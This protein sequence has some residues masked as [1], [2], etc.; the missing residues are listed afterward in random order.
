MERSAPKEMM[1]KQVHTVATAHVGVFSNDLTDSP[2]PPNPAATSTAISLSLSLST[3]L[4]LL[5]FLFKNSS[6]RI[7]SQLQSSSSSYY[8]HNSI[9]FIT[10]RCRFQH[11]SLL[12][13]HDLSLSLIPS[14]LQNSLLFLPKIHQPADLYNL[15][16]L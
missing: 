12:F 14:H 11:P 16:G 4:V 10:S 2:A 15:E 7:F 3:D 13:R 8:T 9:I 1:T 6:N 5:S